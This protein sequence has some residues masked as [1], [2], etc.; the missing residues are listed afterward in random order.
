MR[1]GNVPPVLENLP[2]SPRILL[3]NPTARSSSFKVPARS[4]QG[5]E[6]HRN[7]T[8]FELLSWHRG[9]RPELSNSGDQSP[10]AALRVGILQ[11]QGTCR[12]TDGPFSWRRP[13]GLDLAS[14]PQEDLLTPMEKHKCWN[15]PCSRSGSFPQGH[16]PT[17]QRP[18]A[19]AC[20]AGRQGCSFSE[21]QTSG[22]WVLGL[23]H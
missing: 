23:L 15:P 2:R 22:S 21:A 14:A 4:S 7:P 16:L 18:S 19:W 8:M 20:C 6:R 12:W 9:R 10:A 3:T 13:R 11:T 5:Q 17:T 1:A